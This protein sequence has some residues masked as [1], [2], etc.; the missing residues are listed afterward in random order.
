VFSLDLL[1]DAVVLGCFYA[2]VSIGLSRAPASCLLG[3][4]GQAGARGEVSFTRRRAAATGNATSRN[5]FR[6]EIFSV[7]CSV[8]VL[9]ACYDGMGRDQ[10]R[11]R[12]A[13]KSRRLL[14]R[15]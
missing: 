4:W 10:G 11:P 3:E 2:A 15:G 12:L 8:V 13:L 5:S 14:R 1:R 7:R 9:L 6:L